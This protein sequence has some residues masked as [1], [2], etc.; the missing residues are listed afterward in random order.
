VASREIKVYGVWEGG[1]LERG[2]TQTAKNVE[3]A[4]QQMAEKTGT[5]VSE[6]MGRSMS[7]FNEKTE[8]ARQLMTAFGG[9]L[10]EVAGQATYYAGT[11]SYV[12]G[13]F[14]KMELGIMGAIGAITTLGVSFYKLATEQISAVLGNIGELTKEI[15]SL[16]ASVEKMYESQ[17]NAFLGLDKWE[18]KRLELRS[19]ERAL[20]LEIR[21]LQAEMAAFSAKTGFER[22]LAL[23]AGTA[24]DMTGKLNKAREALMKIRNALRQLGSG[25]SMEADANDD[26][27]GGG[28]GGG[29]LEPT[30]GGFGGFGFDMMGFGGTLDWLMEATGG[31]AGG[32]RLSK[33]ALDA[34]SAYY[35]ASWKLKEENMMRTDRIMQNE[36][37]MIEARER[38]KHK[39]KMQYAEM[40]AGATAELFEVMLSSSKGAFWAE[41]NAWLESKAIQAA[42][43]ALYETA[44]A[45]ATSFWNPAESA[46][47]WTAAGMFASFAALYGAGAGITSGATGGG[48][49]G[50]SVESRAS[51]QGTAQQQMPKEPQ[52]LEV[53][54]GGKYVGRAI[55]DALDDYQDQKTPGRK[56]TEVR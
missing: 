6:G 7:Q 28:G 14:K 2:F 15:D 46:S 26:R 47:H 20:M 45:I 8:K 36:V 23:I 33:M 52:V 4:S 56:R 41:L 51:A 11:L 22:G 18:V 29:V 27:G 3:S 48:G 24:G 30:G 35:D 31:E 50:A 43:Q 5:F 21:D 38:E 39:I 9:T 1:K 44:M 12:A 34:E 13:R 40:A 10:G 32:R 55:N 16:T 17:L 49:G 25:K 19:K 54:I 42:A 53:Y 37:R